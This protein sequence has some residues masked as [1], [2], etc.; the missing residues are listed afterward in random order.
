MAEYAD[1]FYKV[2]TADATI[3]G[4]SVEE[5]LNNVL[6]CIVLS[7]GKEVAIPTHLCQQGAWGVQT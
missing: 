6:T 5:Y 1:D 3:K 4:K 7:M 2:A